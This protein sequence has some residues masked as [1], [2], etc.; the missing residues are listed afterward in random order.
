MGDLCKQRVSA[1]E[2][3]DISIEINRPL[4]RPTNVFSDLGNQ[5][6]FELSL[7]RISIKIS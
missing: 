1:S 4:S 2:E 6:A 3:V 7:R 5:L